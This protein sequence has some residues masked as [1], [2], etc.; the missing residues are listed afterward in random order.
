MRDADDKMFEDKLLLMLRQRFATG[1][2]IRR[3]LYIYAGAPDSDSMHSVRKSVPGDCVLLYFYLPQSHNFKKCCKAPKNEL[4]LS[5]PFFK[6]TAP[7]QIMLIASCVKAEKIIYAGSQESNANKELSLIKKASDNALL[8][9][10]NERADRLAKLRS[11]IQN[12]PLIKRDGALFPQKPNPP[13]PAIICGAGPSA[14]SQVSFLKKISDK[15]I[16]IASGRMGQWLSERGITP[17][18]IVQIDYESECDT[19]WN[20]S[21]ESALVA[22][23]G[24][25]PANALSFR[26]IIWIR[27]DSLFFNRYLDECG[28]KLNSC[29]VS[30]TSTVTCI[31]FALKLGCKKMALIGNDLCLSGS[32]THVDGYYGGNANPYSGNLFEIDGN[33]GGKVWTNHA[34]EILREAIRDFIAKAKSEHEGSEIYNCASEGALIE[35]AKK[36]SLEKFSEKFIGQ[37]DKKISIEPRQNKDAGIDIKSIIEPFSNYTSIIREQIKCSDKLQEELNSQMP[38]MPSINGMKRAMAMMQR[39]EQEL[40]KQANGVNFIAAINETVEDI[41]SETP[42]SASA[43]AN[44]R[45][46]LTLDLCDDLAGDFQYAEKRLNGEHEAALNRPCTTLFAAFRNFAVSFIEPK[47][48]ELAQAL[49]KDIFSKEEKNYRISEAGRDLPIV[50]TF[51]ADGTALTFPE[52]KEAIAGEVDNFLKSSEYDPSKCALIIFAPGNWLTVEAFAKKYPESE[53]MII[54]PWP[55]LLSKIINHSI[56]MHRLPDNTTVVGIHEKMGK[57][58]NVYD[59]TID[60]WNARSKRIL[61]L[62]PADTW[63]LPEIKELFN[64]HFSN[65]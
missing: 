51:N 46:A 43:P 31:D 28:I 44:I 56:F 22:T 62:R 19:P 36:I 47:N 64:A 27:G 40:I 4:T 6:E 23:T 7:D 24:V 49:K 8:N 39:K 60:K 34:F 65:L 33:N 20:P 15:V 12:I 21:P 38:D 1:Q 17:D 35:E 2:E 54:E 18:F 9:L 16:I 11:S 59:E 45:P 55:G 3:L 37:T 14:S 13:L 32:A 26:K 63:R 29:E 50:Y 42:Q 25:S 52:N 61:C 5:I 41:F 10:H 57:W 53:L 30:R 48:P 58:K